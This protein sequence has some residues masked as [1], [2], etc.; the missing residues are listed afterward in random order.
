METVQGKRI[1]HYSIQKTL[2]TGGSCKV[3]LAYD[4]NN[5]NKKVAVKILNDNLG[6]DEMALLNNEITIMNNLGHKHV[7]KYLNH[8]QADY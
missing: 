5:N 2:G 6:D 3:K 4:T 1:E 8:G 7:V